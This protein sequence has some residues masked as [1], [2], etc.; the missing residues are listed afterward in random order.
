MKTDGRIQ[1]RTVRVQRL[2]VALVILLLSNLSWSAESK[3][4]SA[5]EYALYERV[6]A[7]SVRPDMH[8]LGSLS[9]EEYN[10]LQQG[11]RKQIDYYRNKGES[12]AALGS[13]Y[14]TLQL[15]A[16]GDD[17]AREMVVAEFMNAPRWGNRASGLKALREPKVIP[18]IGEALFK[19]ETEEER[20]DNIYKAIQETVRS[21]IV[22]T[23][24]NSAE[25]NEAVI[26]WARRMRSD[27][28]MNP[29]ETAI[30]RDWYRAN[31][32]K[33]KAGD[34]KAVQ[35]GA[36]P[37]ERKQPAP[38][39]TQPPSSSPPSATAGSESKTRGNAPTPVH[40][41]NGYLSI[42]ALLLALCGSLVWLLRRKRT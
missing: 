41:G 13:H 35:P 20:G 25:F 30:L 6:F 42:T 7:A 38:F 10:L 8:E 29:E 21:V 32:A 22:Y 11:L 16:L 36:E 26:N 24:G 31:E 14:E 34:F 37:P 23:V 3:E 28:S 19:E 40:S 1:N 12:A 5:K 15:A 33:L 9:A 4:Q 27:S 39:D 17:N 2:Y 18:M